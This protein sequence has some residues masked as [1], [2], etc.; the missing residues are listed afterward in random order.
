[1]EKTKA[2]RAEIPEELYSRLKECVKNDYTNITGIVRDLIVD[3][4]K[5][6]EAHQREKEEWLM[7][8]ADYSRK[9]GEEWKNGGSL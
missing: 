3:Y 7:E 1:M 2:I 8:L 6:S 4:V 9:F 5:E